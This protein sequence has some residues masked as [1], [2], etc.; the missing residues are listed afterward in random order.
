MS[1][2]PKISNR[3]RIASEWQPS[4][5]GLAYATER[6]IDAEEIEAFRDYHL[7][8]GSLMA[9]WDAAWRTWCRNAV[10]FNRTKPASPPLLQVID[11]ADLWGITAWSRQLPDAVPDTLAG[12]P[13][14][15][16]N[17]YDV[18][19]VAWDICNAVGLP[20]DYRGNL[21]PIADWL[22]A[23]ID[24]DVILEAIRTSKKPDRPNLHYYS[25]RVMEWGQRA[26]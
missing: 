23:G 18:Q 4:A 14:L 8:H 3:T 9:D 11:G 15:A 10:K 5:D 24:P 16:L 21:E 2:Q 25:L 22:R 1:K 20:P 7:A 6:A 19:A 12:E 26:A 17:G 13:I